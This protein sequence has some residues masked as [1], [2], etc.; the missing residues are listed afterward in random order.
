[1][2]K[3][4]NNASEN[5]ARAALDLRVGRVLSNTEWAHARSTLMQ[6][7]TILRNWERNAEAIQ[8]QP[9]AA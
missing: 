5:A 4:N 7:V 8:G 6:F 3:I 1:M 2:E 9:L